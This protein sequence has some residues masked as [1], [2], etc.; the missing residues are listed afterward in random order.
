MKPY[1]IKVPNATGLAF[2]T[3]KSPEE[4]YPEKLHKIHY[5]DAEMDKE[6]TL[7]A[8][9]HKFVLQ[10]YSHSLQKPQADRTVLQIAWR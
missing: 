8:K 10:R 5:Y 4:L 1:I 2:F 3:G 7:L 9:R 6:S